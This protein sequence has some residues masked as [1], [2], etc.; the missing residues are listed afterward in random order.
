MQIEKPFECGEVNCDKA[1]ASEYLLRRHTQKAHE[2]RYYPP[3]QRR[4][5]RRKGMPPPPKKVKRLTGSPDA[6]CLICEKYLANAFEL[7]RHKA[8]RH[9]LSKDFTCQIPGCDS[10]FSTQMLMNRHYRRVHEP[11]GI[12]VSQFLVPLV[13]WMGISRKPVIM[14]NCCMCDAEFVEEADLIQHAEQFHPNQPTKMYPSHFR[15]ECR[16]CLRKFCKRASY[17][18]HFEDKFFI[19]PEE[20]AREERE[21]LR[22]LKQNASKCDDCGKMLKGPIELKNHMQRFHSVEKK[23]ECDFEGCHRR[24]ATMV[25]LNYHREAHEK[26]IFICDFCNVT[27][28]KVQQL[29]AHIQQHV[30]N[31][32][33]APC[34]ICNKIFINEET[35]MVHMESHT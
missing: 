19:E 10:A 35:L 32:G 26:K 6:Y 8:R 27:F 22:A 28:R 3:D 31:E 7:K 34:Q 11:K 5:Q 4:Y 14:T 30:E 13:S 25:S 17:Y 20:A 12:D 24:F 16:Y 21:I 33:V 1:F 2:R 15:I 18:R 23:F 29:K 9:P